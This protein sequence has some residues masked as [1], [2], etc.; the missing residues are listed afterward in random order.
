MYRRVRLRYPVAG[1][2]AYTISKGAVASMTRA[3]A[4]ECLERH[5]NQRYSSKHYRY[6]ANQAMP[7]ADFRSW[8][9]PADLAETIGYL[10]SSKIA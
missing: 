2:S 4:A 3:M 6:T 5:S 10:V 7:H 9:K 1:L 8:P